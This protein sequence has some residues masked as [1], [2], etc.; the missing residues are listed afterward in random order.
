MN[1]VQKSYSVDGSLPNRMAQFKEVKLMSQRS[2]MR[3]DV[4]AGM[5]AQIFVENEHR[6]KMREFFD[7][8][9]ENVSEI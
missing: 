4:E 8:V 5:I 9:R 6:Q 2:V 1:W 3:T 7:T